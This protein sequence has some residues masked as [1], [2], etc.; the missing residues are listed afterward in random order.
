MIRGFSSVPAYQVRAPGKRLVSRSQG[1]CRP[2]P[3]ASP[4]I[5][6]N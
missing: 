1:P 4:L 6:Q 2:T 5:S 3:L